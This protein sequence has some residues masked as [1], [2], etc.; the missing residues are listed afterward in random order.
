LSRQDQ[1]GQ[2]HL[3]RASNPPMRLQEERVQEREGTAT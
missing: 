2:S 1:K 3:D